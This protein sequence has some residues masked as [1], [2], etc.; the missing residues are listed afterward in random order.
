MSRIGVK[1]VGK[2]RFRVARD[3]HGREL[4]HA[5]KEHVIV[6]AGIADQ[7]CSVF[8]VEKNHSRDTDINWRTL[9][10][11][12]GNFR[13]EFQ[14]AGAAP[15]RYGALV[16]ARGLRRAD[17]FAEFH[18]SLVPI[19]GRFDR[20][21]ALRALT[22]LSPSGWLAQIAANCAEPRED[23][24]NVAVKHGE[25][26]IIRNAQNCGGGVVA[27]AGQSERVFEAARKL[28]VM[29]RDDFFCGE[30]Q[31]SRAAVISEPGPHFQN[32]FQPRASQRF[33]RGEFLEEAFVIG[34]H[35]GDARL[36]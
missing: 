12:G 26:H 30:M 29:M 17:Y 13:R 28:S 18:E 20:E 23:A 22:E 1:M 31:I 10:A 34:H 7:E 24:G 21:K 9:L 8:R 25:R 33:N 4:P 14:C 5:R 11:D 27:D 2:L 32:F 16:A 19:A 15:T 36:L 3:L 35:R 6:R